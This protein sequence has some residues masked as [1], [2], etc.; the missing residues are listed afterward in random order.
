MP[1]IKSLYLYLFLAAATP[2]AAPLELK[3][4]SPEPPTVVDESVTIILPIT[5]QLVMC[6]SELTTRQLS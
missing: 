2:H 6:D 5:S 4:L 3:A 1:A